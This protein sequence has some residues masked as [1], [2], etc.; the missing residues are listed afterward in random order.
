MRGKVAMVVAVAAML[1]GGWGPERAFAAMSGSRHSLGT[2]QVTAALPTPPIWMAERDG[3][4]VIVMAVID[5]APA[6]L[7]WRSARLDHLLN[8]ATAVVDAPDLRLRLGLFGGLGAMATAV[9]HARYPD[10][11]SLQ[12]H[13]APTD[14]AEVQQAEQYYNHGDTDFYRD[15]P[16]FA[17][18]VLM[19]AAL[20]QL[21]YRRH[22]PVVAGLLK[23]FAARRVSEVR[24][25]YQADLEQPTAYMRELLED[26]D[27]AMPCLTALA[28]FLDHHA[29]NL[30]AR[31]EAWSEGDTDA[32]ART[33]AHAFDICRS[34][35]FPATLL[36]RHGVTDIDG[37]LMAVWRSAVIKASAD[38]AVVFAWL[39]MGALSGAHDYLQA[40]QN[41]GFQ[42]RRW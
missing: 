18:D 42:L 13:L 27:A 7:L 19:D 34:S 22:S 37:H 29:G 41:V 17:A 26:D 12:Q 8:Q 36:A 2:V 10:H 1:S 11:G 31:A 3:H 23:G 20:R 32:L 33:E 28:D 39:P 5:P 9:R 25:V 35:H 14:F 40:L 24:P 16:S 30:Q 15:R 6:D 38:H 4:T 21:G